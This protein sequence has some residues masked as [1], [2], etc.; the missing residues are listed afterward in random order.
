MRFQQPCCHEKRGMVAK[1]FALMLCSGCVRH[2]CKNRYIVV[3]G[4]CKCTCHAKAS[5][6]GS[7]D[8]SVT[9]SNWYVQDPPC[10]TLLPNGLW[11]LPEGTLCLVRAAQPWA[12]ATWRARRSAR[13]PRPAA[14]RARR[15]RARRA[16]E[17]ARTASSTRPQSA[18]CSAFLTPVF[19]HMPL[20][21]LAAIVIT[22]VLGLLDFGRVAHPV[23]G[24]GCAPSSASG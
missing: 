6:I 1:S 4:F 5:S 8:P 22:G 21:A 13:T 10:L 15:W 20:N 7:R 2:S 12:R 9:V 18:S 19:Q 23:T 24:G 3:R 17:Q 11:S 14:L 16:P